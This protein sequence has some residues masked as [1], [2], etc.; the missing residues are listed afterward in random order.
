MHSDKK[1]LFHVYDDH[2]PGFIFLC[3]ETRLPG[4]HAQQSLEENTWIVKK[5]IVLPDIVLRRALTIDALP[6]NKAI[7]FSA[8]VLTC[9]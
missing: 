1:Q 2:Y 9:S 3:L 8:H 7:S 5:A 4:N 6:G